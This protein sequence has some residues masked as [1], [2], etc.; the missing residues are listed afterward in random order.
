MKVFEFFVL[1]V[2]D[3]LRPSGWIHSF[4]KWEGGIC[5]YHCALHWVY[6]LS[7]VFSCLLTTRFQMWKCVDYL[8]CIYVNACSMFVGTNIT[9]HFLKPM[10][11]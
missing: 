7:S 1:Y 9:F 8:P 5:W 4:Q 11:I 6:S 3:R 10:A 2:V